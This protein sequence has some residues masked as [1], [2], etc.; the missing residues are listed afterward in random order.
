MRRLNQAL[1]LYYFFRNLKTALKT[2]FR[3]PW[4]AC[5]LVSMSEESGS[6][7][8]QSDRVDAIA[9]YDVTTYP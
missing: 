5:G 7:L 1:D 9:L 2:L 4:P 3:D 8:Y 6:S